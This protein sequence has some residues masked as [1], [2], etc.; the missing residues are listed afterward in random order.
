MRQL[1]RKTRHIRLA[2]YSI[3]QQ[4]HQEPHAVSSNTPF[5]ESVN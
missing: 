2:A 3:C 5:L 1:E 4:T